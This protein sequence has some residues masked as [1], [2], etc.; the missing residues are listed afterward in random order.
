MLLLSW[1]L[2]LGH[3][4]VQQCVLNTTS[5]VAFYRISNLPNHLIPFDFAFKCE[6]I[7]QIIFKIESMKINLY[8]L[9]T[10]KRFFCQL[11]G[12]LHLVLD[13]SELC[14][15]IVAAT[16]IYVC[17]VL[18]SRVGRDLFWFISH[19]AVVTSKRVDQIFKCRIQTNVCSYGKVLV[20]CWEHFSP[21][22]EHEVLLWCERSPPANALGFA[23]SPLLQNQSL[24]SVPLVLNTF[25]L[26]MPFHYMYSTI[27][28]RYGMGWIGWDNELTFFQFFCSLKF[29]LFL[30]EPRLE[31]W[32]ANKVN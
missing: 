15:K 11:L 7:F 21:T 23:G 18:V 9:I 10:M 17:L 30:F 29:S 2:S 3:C 5:L 28:Q 25:I 4:P 16:L 32:K 19:H 6:V 20:E 8:I 31:I 24:G 14:P 22:S 1:F 26:H 13:E 27:K 12:D